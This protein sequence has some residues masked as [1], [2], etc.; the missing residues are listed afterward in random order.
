MT[1]ETVLGTV[2][3]V[4]LVIAAL[5][6]FLPERWNPLTALDHPEGFAGDDHNVTPGCFVIL[7]TVLL[8]LFVVVFG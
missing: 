7:A 8:V 2:G 5:L 3:V 4:L 6:L 1:P